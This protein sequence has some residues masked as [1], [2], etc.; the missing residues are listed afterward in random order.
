MV[1]LNQNIFEF[2]P[3]LQVISQSAILIIDYTEV[4]YYLIEVAKN[5]LL[6]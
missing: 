3:D 1:L 2:I 6:W 4:P 5:I